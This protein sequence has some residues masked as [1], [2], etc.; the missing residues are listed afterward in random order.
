M[1]INE[2]KLKGSMYGVK[3]IELY[4]NPSKKNVKISIQL[5]NLGLKKIQ[6]F[7]QKHQKD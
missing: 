1:I 6:L 2:L 4:K 5:S 7:L 3:K